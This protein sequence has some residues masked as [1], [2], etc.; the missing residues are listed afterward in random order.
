MLGFGRFVPASQ[1]L[2]PERKKPMRQILLLQ[3]EAL[4]ALMYQ[5][6]RLPL[7]LARMAQMRELRA[8]LAAL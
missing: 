3:I 2:I 1:W 6:Q 5:P 4:D 8:Q 7:L